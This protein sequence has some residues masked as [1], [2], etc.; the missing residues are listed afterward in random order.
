M[1]DT[2]KRGPGRPKGTRNKPGAKAGRPRKDAMKIV[3]PNHH[4][5][6]PT[7]NA[8]MHHIFWSR[9]LFSHCFWFS[10]VCS[11]RHQFQLNISSASVIW[12]AVSRSLFCFHSYRQILD[13]I[14]SSE[15]GTAVLPKSRPRQT[16]LT[17]SQGHLNIVKSTLGLRV[18]E[19]FFIVKHCI[20]LS[21]VY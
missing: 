18:G 15:S 11:C 20:Y 17:F 19:F 8:G 4:T 9:D 6:L 16:T 10:V 21:H 2:Q 12:W 3:G 1:S 14:Y 13:L 7:Q 5:T